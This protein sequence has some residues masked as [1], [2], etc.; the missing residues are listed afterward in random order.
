MTSSEIK[1]RKKRKSPRNSIYLL[2]DNGTWRRTENITD[3][4]DWREWT[5]KIISPQPLA[6][7][8]VKVLSEDFSVKIHS[9]FI[10]LGRKWAKAYGYKSDGEREELLSNLVILLRCY[11]LFMYQKTEFLSLESSC[12]W[13]T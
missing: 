13:Y 7:R 4:Q 9:K 11:F 12:S 1:K 3:Y 10:K 2:R 6:D 5:R 8:R